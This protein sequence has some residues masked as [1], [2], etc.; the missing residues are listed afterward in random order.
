MIKSELLDKIKK[1]PYGPKSKEYFKKSLEIESISNVYFSINEFPPVITKGK[2]ALVWDLDGKEYID[3][4]SGFSVHNVGHCHP[5][6]VKAIKAQSDKLLQWC[7]MPNELR[8]QYST[9]LVEISPGKSKKKVHL[10]ATGGEAVE[11][12]CNIARSNKSKP[13]IMAFQ[14]CYH[15]VTGGIINAT[16]HPPFRV[17]NPFL[18]NIGFVHVPYAYCYRCQFGRE[19]PDCGMFCTD[20][21]EGLLNNPQAGLSKLA[22][23]LVE[24][25][26]GASGYI[27]PPTEFLKELRRITESHDLLLIVD[28]I[29]TGGCRSGKMWA[30][31][32][33]NIDPDIMTVAKSVGG[34]LPVSA[35]IGKEAI[36]DSVG[37]SGS[38]STFGG[39]PL[40]CAAG[41]ASI[42]IME[43]EKLAEKAK[44]SGKYL[45]SRLNELAKKHKMI[46]NVN[47]R[48]LFIGV[49]LVRDKKTK[50]PAGEEN[51]AL[52]TEC[53]KRGVLYERGG[54]YGNIV[55]FMPSLNISTEL[56]DKAI[57][58]LDQALTV[59]EG[60]K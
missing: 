43:T 40:S 45:T 58:V 13:L 24:P 52:Q 17:S 4:A 22:A 30:C 34:G 56:I 33:S 41:L 42:K 60:K 54:F 2:N 29:Q 47:G 25:M 26:L 46:G 38:M 27:I 23:I 49:E 20:Y 19:Y 18:Q 44:K 8:L 48:G 5:E 11:F 7:A 1:G 57:N 50:E 59:V 55:K 12:A 53:Q 39:T 3:L 15:G 6:V 37:I 16:T 51:L 10:L 31:E 28:E 14:G 35:V 32:Y 21:I 36:M 9:K